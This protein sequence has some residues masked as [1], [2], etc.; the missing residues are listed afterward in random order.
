MKIKH[1][2]ARIAE[3][4]AHNARVDTIRN[5]S[6]SDEAVDAIDTMIREA[7]SFYFDIMESLYSG[8]RPCLTTDMLVD[9]HE[10]IEKLRKQFTKEQVNEYLLERAEEEA[11]WGDDE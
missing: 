9:L 1:A 3:I 11:T 2:T 8:C 10:A 6:L 5:K 7:D 4:K